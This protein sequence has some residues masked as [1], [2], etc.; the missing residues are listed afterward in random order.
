MHIGYIPVLLFA[1]LSVL[2]V[3]AQEADTSKVILLDDVVVV[4]SYTR[5]AK[6]HSALPIEVVDKGF[7]Q[8][9]FR[10]NLMQ[11]L[12][13]VP[14]IHSM[15]I[16]SG[17]S[18]PVIR[19]MGFNRISVA[20]NGIKQE[21]QQWG[22]DHG[23]EIDA[24]N[25]ERVSIIKG[26]ASLL[27]GSDAMGG[28]IE[29]STLSSPIENQ[30]SGEV[31]LLGKSVNETAGGSV[32]LALKKNA[33]Y[34][35]FRFTEQHFGDYR[36][37]TD[38]IV[39]LTQRLPIDRQR[40]KNTAGLERDIALY[41]QYHNRRYS[42][43]Y[44]ISNA[45]QKVG[46]FSGAH[47]IPDPSRVSDDGNN[48]NIE[49]PYSTVNHLKV[50]THQQYVWNQWI[51]YCDIGIQQNHREEWSLFHTHYGERQPKPEINPNKELAFSLS[52]Y[53]SSL[54]AKWLPSTTW[55]HT[56]GWDMQFQQNTIAGYSF[57]LPEY[58]RFTTG[59]FVLSSYRPRPNLYISGG[60]RFDYGN[61]DAAAY[62]DTH[63]EAFLQE[64][65]TATDII[66]GYKWRSYEVKRN[67]NNVSGSLGM[68]WNLSD[69]QMLKANIGRSFRLPGA[70]ELASN[71]VHHGTFR[72][73]QGDA[74]LHSEQGW[75]MDVSHSYQQRGISLEVTPFV[76]WFSNYIYLRPTGEWSILPHAGQ[77]YRYTGIE[78]LFAGAEIRL[79]I[80]F[81]RH[82]NYTISGEYVYAQNQSRNIPLAFSPPTSIRNRVKWTKKS[83]QL[84]SEWQS[85]FDQY[86]VANNEPVTPGANLLHGGGMIS[87]PFNK[88]K[89]DVSLSIQNIFNTKYYNHLSFY[90]RVEIPEPGRNFQLLIN[91]P[92]SVALN[93][94]K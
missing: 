28:I 59:V 84:Y 60:I 20:E 63:L 18:K 67:F 27:Y 66:E 16:G 30:F 69:S 31:M 1:M 92:F 8:E 35:K 74:S 68:V 93:S 17:F 75:Q 29:I 38:T 57:L 88:T 32:G 7:L 55:E 12:Q 64:Q 65:N 49:L 72:H 52:T 76:S 15:N 50:S 46:F 21:G 77:V 11:T 91:I 24:F 41:S 13:H 58:R 42:A 37:P 47:G 34:T 73:E 45:Y 94:E 33:W 26:P 82:L 23:L 54:K 48:R 89:V 90:R 40:L 81:L 2:P 10:G 51:G 22:A 53:S 78:A 71:G 62:S 79:G 83:I 6:N 36:I 4:S 39:Y 3:Y 70:N 14:G 80:D 19:G 86:R 44:A 61:I 56:A 85:I 43:N 9:H 87:I 5:N 25:A